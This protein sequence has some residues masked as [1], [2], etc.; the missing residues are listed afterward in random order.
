M[1]GLE[2][3]DY[4]NDKNLLCMFPLCLAW[5]VSFETPR[6]LLKLEP[7]SKQNPSHVDSSIFSSKLQRTVNQIYEAS[8]WGKVG[9]ESRPLYIQ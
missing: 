1:H 9:Y 6:S 2:N 3:Q 7:R 5:R 8:L 4:E